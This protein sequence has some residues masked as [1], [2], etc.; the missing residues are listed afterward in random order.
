VAFNAST[1][2]V[3]VVTNLVVTSIVMTATGAPLLLAN[4]AAVISASLVN[5]VVSDRL[6]FV[7]PRAAITRPR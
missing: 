7:A 6:V 4:L 3:S 5:F 1:G 2:A